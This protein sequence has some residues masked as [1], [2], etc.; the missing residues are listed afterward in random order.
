M[1][2]PV[3]GE[4]PQPNT[5]T[6]PEGGEQPQ[7]QQPFDAQ[8]AISGM[9]D[10]KAIGALLFGN[11]DAAPSPKAEAEPSS[12]ANANSP[13]EPTTLPQNPAGEQPQEI[14][15]GDAPQE[16][17][18]NPQS[19]DRISLKSLHPDERI[20]IA[21]AKDMVREG[22]A[23]SFVDAFASLVKTEASTQEPNPQAQ[24]QESQPQEQI[25]APAATAE[26]DQSVTAI[27]SR[28]VDLRE[29]RKAAVE[30]Y[31]RPTEI[32]LTNQIEDALADLAEAKSAAAL[33]T[34]ETTSQNQ[35]I[36]AVI[37]DIYVEHPDAE[38]PDSYFSYR[39]TRELAAYEQAH[40]SIRNH[41]QQLKG[42][43]SRIASELGQSTGTA[44]QP[45][46][47]AQQIQP[48]Q[49]ARPI[50]T[51]APGH[52]AAVRTSPD[53][54]QSLINNASAEELRSALFGPA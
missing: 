53:Q 51:A 4:Q 2:P 10:E 41:P 27:S 35:A 32:E 36:D 11:E 43:A 13:A 3:A 17:Q 29:Q 40:G 28:L 52:S 48:R 33:R 39:M 38:D 12:P 44:Q 46:A 15:Q 34:R 22:K 42:I 23:A 30:A 47:A 8:S 25:Q 26:Q 54:L 9:N 6:L 45:T 31:D 37:Q 18:S 20:L 50:G 49:I 1:E 19:L 16:P 24:A 21:Q 14:A 7:Q 5:Q